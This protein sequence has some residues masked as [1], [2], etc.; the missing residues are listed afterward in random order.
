MP[1][2]KKHHYVPKFYLKRFSPSG[3]SINI[4]NIKNRKTISNGNLKNQCYQDYFYGKEQ[5]VEKSLSIIENEA[6]E[7]L[8]LIDKHGFSPPFDQNEYL[9]LTLY[10]LT[11][12]GRTAYSADRLDE[13]Q[14]KLMKH[15]YREQA[16]ADGIDI[17]D[18]F[19]GIQDSAKYSLFMSIQSYP[20]LLDMSCKLI[21]NKTNVDF[22]TSDNP[23]IFYNQLLSFR[24][25][26][27]NTGIASKGLQIFFPISSK[28]L[29]VFYDPSSYRIGKGSSPLLD[30]TL[31]QDVYELNALQMVSAYENVYFENISLNVNSLYRKSEKFRKLEKTHLNVFPKEQIES[32]RRE[33]VAS[34]KADIVT[35][36]KLSFIKVTKSAK[37]WRK[38]FKTQDYQP[39]M[40][41]RN[42]DLVDK[43][44]E[45]REKN[46]N[47]FF[48]PTDFFEFLEE[49]DA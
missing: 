20:L 27:S 35:N 26:V 18:F 23:V 43:F 25:Y 21:T 40:L 12:Y 29:L 44:E 11:Q 42:E 4:W 14:D 48:A 36:L 45:F 33:I 1:N 24:T 34:S 31:P 39:A 6:A 46:T 8:K 41:V 19:I 30:I 5:Q 9:T 2:N 22:V 49:T 17:D 13:M 10:V 16:K 38:H 3:K 37:K 32:E 7:A 28:K 15:L 47:S